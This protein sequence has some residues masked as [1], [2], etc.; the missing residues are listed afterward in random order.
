MTT[1]VY[2]PRYALQPLIALSAIFALCLYRFSGR[3]AGRGLVAL[4]ALSLYA[5][6]SFARAASKWP[7]EAEDVAT[8]SKVYRQFSQPGMPLVVSS[9]E[10][11]LR[12]N[13]YGSWCERT[14][15]FIFGRSR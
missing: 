5:N 8:V 6:V 4:A 13:Y 11:W 3:S 10:M 9:I 14:S 15:C 1:G 7:A 2:T 12:L